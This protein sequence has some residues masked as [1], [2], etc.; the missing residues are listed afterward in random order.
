MNIALVTATAAENEETAICA[1]V[2]IIF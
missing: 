2:F 1:A